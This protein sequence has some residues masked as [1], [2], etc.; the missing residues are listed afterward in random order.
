MAT[1]LSFIDIFAI[2]SVILIQVVDTTRH[3][4]N[5]DERI[6]MCKLMKDLLNELLNYKSNTYL[7]KEL[8][9]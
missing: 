5:I 1:G 8:S 4:A 3:T 2:L 9:L 6:F 7:M